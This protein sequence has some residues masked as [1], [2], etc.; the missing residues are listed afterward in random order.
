MAE[1][2]IS[3]LRAASALAVV[4]GAGGL[5]FVNAGVAGA[6]G[7]GSP[8]VNQV[9]T[10]CST[11]STITLSTTNSPQTASLGETCAF[12]PNSVVTVTFGGT[13]VSSPNADS[14]GLITLSISAEDP[15]IS[16]NGSP[17]Q[18]AVYGTNTI[19]AI[20]TNASGAQNTATFLVDLVQAGGPA[21]SSS[22]GGGGLAF[23]GADL[24]ALDRRRPGPRSPLGVGV[25][26]VTP[27][28]GRQA[29]AYRFARLSPVAVWATVS[30][31]S[32]GP[33][34]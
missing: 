21:S 17:Y 28:P 22:T 19:T 3:I 31:G 6:A 34:Q 29:H 15:S 12:T 1:R 2:R 18:G 5:L 4:A 9:P 20:G 7:S 8:P 33:D 32:S 16:I 24:A 13:V 26:T 14:S 11:S 25:V 23:T 27:P 30:E 10:S